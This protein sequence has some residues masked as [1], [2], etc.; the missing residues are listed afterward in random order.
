MGVMTIQTNVGV[1]L[2]EQGTGSFWPKAAIVGCLLSA[3]L[4]RKQTVR[5]PPHMGHWPRRVGVAA[6][7][8]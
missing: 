8:K 6:F 4:I 1:W 3:R 7:G 5:N 2:I